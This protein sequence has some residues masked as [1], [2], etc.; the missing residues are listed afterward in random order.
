MIK[1]ARIDELPARISDLMESLKNAEKEIAAFNR[2]KAMQAAA[3]LISQ[4]QKINGSDVLVVQ[5][6]DGVAV[7]D[8]RVISLDLRNKLA[9]AIVV[10][11][12]RGKEK[13]TIV[14]ALSEQ[15]R[16]SGVKA[17]ELVKVG[18]AVLGGGGGGKDDF[19]QGGGAH[20]DKIKE[21]LEAIARQ[22]R[23]SL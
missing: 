6:M 5:I 18:S 7:D 14:A 17:G 8:L 10:L 2:E 22:I 12:S 20:H 11:A 16:N 19:A 3:T 4:A 13:T 9:N 21:A 23:E 15:A 1:G